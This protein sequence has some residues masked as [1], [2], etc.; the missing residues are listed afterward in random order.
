MLLLH[1]LLS[2][3][4]CAILLQLLYFLLVLRLHSLT[5]L[6]LLLLELLKVLLALRV[7]LR[8]YISSRIFGPR[9]RLPRVGW[10]WIRCGRGVG[11]P[12]R[13]FRSSRI[14]GWSGVV[15]GSRL[16]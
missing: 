5:L 15:W 3:L 14:F 2:F 9:R 10:L 11:W 7:G 6:A 16:C 12:I 1:C 4:V 13:S 8:I